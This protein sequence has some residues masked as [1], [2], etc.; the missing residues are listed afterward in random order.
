M[1]KQIFEKKRQSFQWKNFC[2]LFFLALSNMKNAR[3][4]FIRV[5]KVFDIYRANDKMIS[6]PKRWIE[7]NISK[8]S[9]FKGEGKFWPNFPHNIECDNP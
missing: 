7:T 1:K 9:S 2:W 8:K 5:S 3:E 6:G 4:H